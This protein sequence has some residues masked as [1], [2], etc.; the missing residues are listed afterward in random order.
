MKEQPVQGHILHYLMINGIFAWKNSNGSTYDPT[1][2]IFR[3]KT[4]Y[5]I[6]GV[7]DILGILPDGRF[8][9]IEVKRFNPKTYPSQPQKYFL[10]NINKSNGLAFV[11]WRLEDVIEMLE[12]YGYAK[13][14]TGNDS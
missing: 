14:L 2:K 4:K 5:E 1:R 6:N 10:T 12:K 9:A 8:L 13:S 11:A 7:S 3:R